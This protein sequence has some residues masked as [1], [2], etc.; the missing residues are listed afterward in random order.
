MM[1]TLHFKL[2]YRQPKVKTSKI[3]LF[4]DFN[5]LCWIK[6]YYKRNTNDK[7]K[8]K[9]RGKNLF[10]FFVPRVGFELTDP[11]I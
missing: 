7:T 11:K 6:K 10:A 4:S 1:G 3:A 9:N 5:P 8:G 2:V